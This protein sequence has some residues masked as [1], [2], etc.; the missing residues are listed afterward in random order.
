MVDESI[1]RLFKS[2]RS[3]GWALLTAVV[4]VTL[5]SACATLSTGEPKPAAS[6][7]MDYF[8]SDGKKIA[9]T[10]AL[11]KL[12]I[13]A[14]EGV[15]DKAIKDFIRSFDWKILEEYRGGLFIVGLGKPIPRQDLTKL[16]WELAK[17]GE[18]L[19]AIV[20]KVVTLIQR[21]RT[22]PMVVSDQFTVRFK[23]DIPKEK[24]EAFNKSNNVQTIRE[25]PY[26]KG[27]FLLKTTEASPFD[28]LQ[29]ADL[30]HV[31]GLTKYAYPNFL[32]VF[33]DTGEFIPND[34]LFGYQWH[35][36]NTGQ[37]SGTVDADIDTPLAWGITQGN[38]GTVI[39]VVEIGG[40]DMTH[41][42]LSPN[43]ISGWDFY[44]CNANP[45]SGCGDSD[46]TG[47]GL[48]GSHGTAVAGV[49]A[50]RG[51]NSL[52]VSGS[53]PQCRLMLLKTHPVITDDAKALVI[54]YAQANGA[55]VINNSWANS[56]ALPITVE[57]IETAVAAGVVVLFSAGNTQDNV[58]TGGTYLPVVANQ[59]V[60]AVSGSTN[61]D[62]KVVRSAVGNC[63]D[64]LAPTHRGY[65]STDPYTGT[66][67]ITTTDMV[68]GGSGY[69]NANLILNCPSSEDIPPLP[70]IRDYTHCFGGT[71]AATPLTAGVVGLMLTV[72]QNLTPLQ[73]K[74]L[75]QDT[76]DKIQ[77]GVASYA[78][79]TGFSGVASH[80]WGRLNAFEAVRI[81]APVS[82]GGKGGV[83]IFLRDNRLDW[84]NTEQPSNTLFEPTR[85][86]IDHWQ[87]M[88]IK[89]DAP[90]VDAPQYRTPPTAATFDAFTDET[91]SAAPGEINRVYVRVRNRGPVTAST[92]TVKL[93]WTQ[94][95]TA[96]PAL[97]S[98]FW[99]AFPADSTDTSQWHPLNCAGTTSTTCTVS[100]LTYSGAS[101]VATTGSDAAQI[102]RFDFP[103]PPVDPMLPNHFC[104]LAMIDSSQ[105]PISTESKV[106]DVVDDITPTDNNVTHRNYRDLVIPLSMAFAAAASASADE[107]AG[108]HAIN[109]VLSVPA[110]STPTPITGDVTDA[111]SGSATLGTD[112]TAVGTVTLTFSAG[113]VD[114]AIQV[115][116][117]GVLADALVEG[118][119]T[120]N[121]QLGNVTGTGAVLGAQTTHTAT[122]TDDD[123]VR[124]TAPEPPTGL[125]IQ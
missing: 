89:V 26:V 14:R 58:C 122:I 90:Q 121:L 95:D 35:H 101:V 10:V 117:L 11:D 96:L 83:D 16:V 114:G 78:D 55:R 87:S 2:S 27:Q 36:K 43:I 3:I 110:G 79:E 85:G 59:H 103:A 62:R 6:Q 37:G 112:Y 25:N 13:L 106:K 8:F 28:G 33:F 46:P 91:P 99:T 69:N 50:A 40:F 64:I 49:A 56:A 123:Q 19:I 61:Q 51:N 118:N 34:E 119:E 29:M 77:P 116:N 93:H 66:L 17:R 7:E 76:A 72:N 97:P 73:V 5:L 68:G 82:Q 44:A 52:G 81:A 94:F 15:T 102:V 75:L 54:S 53:C 107:A 9:V 1:S 32:N 42:D 92:V 24:I 23:P 48:S 124:P 12:G 113:A 45:V 21:E 71:S 111:L 108:N 125:G 63:I 109:V 88:D 100:N 22:T 115:F 60:I 104:L 47:T 84:G 70:N 120:V 98:D 86:F 80:S 65:A 20:G 30:Y 39:A 105:D 18:N 57:A 74:R 31:S 41:P 67:N 4:V 38:A